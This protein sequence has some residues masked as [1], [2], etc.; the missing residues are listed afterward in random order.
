MSLH[1]QVLC[2]T[3]GRVLQWEAVP[4]A[5]QVHG[6]PYARW[7]IIVQVCEGCLHD[8]EHAGHER[9]VSEQVPVAHLTRRNQCVYWWS[10]R[11]LCTGP[12]PSP[13]ACRNCRHIDPPDS[14][15]PHDCPMRRLA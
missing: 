12:D 2:G 7:R 1:A 6:T 3:C 9:A 14:A 11:H 15:P 4:V 8:A 5:G 13:T 10:S